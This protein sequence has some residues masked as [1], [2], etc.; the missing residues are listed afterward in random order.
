[1]FGGSIKNINEAKLA[2][3]DVL[4]V[5]PFPLNTAISIYRDS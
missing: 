5:P 2:V 4:P 3:I 1:M